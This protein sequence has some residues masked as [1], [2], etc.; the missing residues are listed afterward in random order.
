MINRDRLSGYM[1]AWTS[2]IIN[3]ILFVFK[4]WIGIQVNSVAMKA[5]AW[6]T[7]SDTLTS[8]IVI[9]SFW[10]SSRQPDKDHPFGHGR[11]ELIGTVII[12]TILAVVG[13]NFLK[14][15]IY[16]LKTHR[17]VVYSS[18]SIIVFAMTIVIK[19]GL[20]WA[21][22]LTGKKI[23]SRALIIDGWHH[24]S[25]AIT[26]TLVVLGALV[27]KYFW[28][29]DGVIGLMVS[30]FILYTTYDIL[31]GA[32]SALLGERSDPVI[33]NKL[34]ELISKIVPGV[35]KL[36]HLHIHKYGNHVELTFHIRLPASMKLRRAHNIASL[37][38]KS[39][40]GDLQ[41]EATIH[42][43]PSRK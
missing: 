23:N 11:A 28:W 21:S 3:V 8:L 43:E 33:E 13:F 1:V 37:I 27:G 2:C 38:E 15:S 19:E 24:R 42:I 12:G 16:R 30:I 18:I 4:Y 5:D 10:I 36:H 31:R 39:I 29:I 17:A 34:M 32:F 35:S 14:E 40:S 9:L 26:T 20:A 7:L 6:H 41:M 22:I 25:D